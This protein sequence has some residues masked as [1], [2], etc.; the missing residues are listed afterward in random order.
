MIFHYTAKAMTEPKDTTKQTKTKTQ[1][2]STTK[3]TKERKAPA[4]RTREAGKPAKTPRAGSSLV[5]VESPAKAR[6]IEK[7]LGHGYSV[8]ASVGHVIDLP[9]SKLGVNI[10]KDFEPE[11]VVIKGKK[12]ILDDLKASAAAAQNIY[13]ATD[14]DREGEAIARHIADYIHTKNDNIFR[15]TFNEITKQAVRDAIANPTIINDNLCMA[16]Q[17]R[18]IL[19][20]LVGYQISPLLWDKVKRGLSAGRVQSVAVRLLCEREAEVLAFISEEYW[21]I[22]TA[23]EATNPPPFRLRLA[24]IDG[25]KKVIPSQT[26]AQEIIDQVRNEPFIIRAIEKKQLRRNPQPPFITSTLEQEGARKLR[27]SPSQTMRIAQQLYEGIDIGGGDTVGLITYMRTDS[28]RLAQSAVDGIREYIQQKHGAEYLPE[29]PNVYASK[30]GAQDAHEAVRPTVLDRPPESLANYL[31]DDQMGL[32]RLIWDRF[33]ASQ[34]KP[35]QVEQTTIEVP[36][37]NNKYLFITTGSVITFPGFLK[38]YEEG[39]D[40]ENGEKNGDAD[41]QADRL[42]R[43]TEGEQLKVGDFF[44][45]QHF[46]QPPPSL[47]HELADTRTRKTRH[48]TP[49]NLP[50]NHLHH[51]GQSLCRTRQRILPPHR[52]GKDRNHPPHRKLPRS[53]R[54]R[55]HRPNGTGTR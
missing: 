41:Q 2:T 29:K 39:R 26:A 20:R 28:T 55:L 17:T 32:Y 45:E 11:Y 27:L 25:E 40:Q 19:D 37:L 49:L 53:P 9:T 54:H 1:R 18:R 30:K 15:A 23:V 12:K 8:R 10:E 48:R 50:H 31:D 34:M 35:A 13:I 3:T 52:I 47:Q 14:P 6:T 33:L 43:V 42:P 5:I 22:E 38:V 51:S 44:P 46:T 4:K 16:Q 7:Y 36:V 24:K 21:S